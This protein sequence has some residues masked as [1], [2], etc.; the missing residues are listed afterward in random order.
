MPVSLL[1]AY[2]SAATKGQTTGIEF[3]YLFE[4]N[5]VDGYGAII[6]LVTIK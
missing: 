1:R 6:P 2:S 5:T 3:P 4:I